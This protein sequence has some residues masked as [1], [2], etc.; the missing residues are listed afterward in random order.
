LGECEE[1]ID[2]KQYIDIEQA[3]MGEHVRGK[4]MMTSRSNKRLLTFVATVLASAV[5][6]A[7]HAAPITPGQ[8]IFPPAEP[9]PTGGVVQAGTGVAVPFASSG[10]PGA[11]TG[12][13]T[14]TVIAGD[15]S[16]PLGG[17][18]FTYRLTDDATS[19][20]ALERMTNLDFT[21]FQTDVSVQTPAAGVVPF[22]IDRDPSSSTVGW[23]FNT[24]GGG[25]INP[26]QASALLVIQTDAPAFAPINA[27]IEDGAVATAAS[28]GPVPEPASL[29]VLCLGL[30]TARRRSRM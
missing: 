15:P 1:F 27:N 22:T 24:S 19:L 10:G 4:K 13:L 5:A 17:L 3:Q 9:D 29:G 8:T 21:G 20:S 2:C 25:K 16:N 14:T 28:F 30:L 11:F 18:T 7:V 26:G 12:T 6:A 23:S